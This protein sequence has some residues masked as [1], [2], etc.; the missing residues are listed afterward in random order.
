MVLTL[1]RAIELRCGPGGEDHSQGEVS[2]TTHT[3]HPG[4]LQ[5]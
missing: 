4:R 5:P 3:F 2:S 1:A